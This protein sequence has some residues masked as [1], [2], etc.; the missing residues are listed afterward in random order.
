MKKILLFLFFIASFLNSAMLLK[1][2]DG[3][4]LA[5]WVMSQKYDGVRAIWDGKSLKSR[6]N[7]AF[8]APKSFL[9]KLPPFAL[10]GELYTKKGDFENISSIVKNCDERWQTIKYM[11]FDSPDFSGNLESRL[12][13]LRKFLSEQNATNIVI[14]EQ[15]PI[16]KTEDAFTFLEQ[17]TAGGGEGI[18]VRDPNAPYKHGRQN[19]ILKL[20]KFKDSECK[21]LKIKP[22]KDDINAIG[23][24]LCQDLNSKITFK[25]GSGFG[26]I[27]LQKGDIITYKYQNLT[28]NKKP[29]FAVFLRK[30]DEF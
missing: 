23:S 10:D 17:I 21:V 3:R 29:R 19:S 9:E 25:I 4:N 11:I 30:K 7:K 28:K 15:K 13:P 8:C 16:L 24:V 2:Y 18:V 22:R 12:A 20:K 27:K 26:G 1:T 5:G 6:Q 14:I